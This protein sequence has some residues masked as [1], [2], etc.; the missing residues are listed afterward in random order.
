MATTVTTAGTLI[1][2]S[3]GG[4]G[5][6]GCFAR[7]VDGNLP[8]LLSNAHVLFSDGRNLKNLC[9]SR[10][11]SSSACL[12]RPI[13]KTL[14]SWEAGFTSVTV[15]V[16]DTSTGTTSSQSGSD[17]DCAIAK[18]NPDTV[19][20]N[21]F[22]ANSQIGIIQGTPPS[23]Q[24]GIVVGPT[25]G[26]PAPNQIV[27]MYSPARQVTIEGT[28]VRFTN[29]VAQFAHNALLVP[30]LLYPFTLTRPEDE[31][32]DAKPNINQILIVPLPPHSKFTEPG[33]SGSILLNHLNQAV[34]L[35]CRGIAVP[36]LAGRP[37]F[38]H[39]KELGI[40]NPI[41]SVLNQ[42]KINIPAGFSGTVPSAGN[43]VRI[44]ISHP[45]FDLHTDN[46]QEPINRLQKELSRIRLGRMLMEKHVRH[47]REMRRILNTVRHAST[48][49]Q[50]A[51]GPA[52]VR[53]GAE[54]L[55]DP[56]HVLP[57]VINGVD[58][59]TFVDR[60]ATVFQAYGSPELRRDVERYLP[61]VRDIIT[62][63]TSLHEVT[64]LLN[65]VRRARRNQEYPPGAQL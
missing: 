16:T 30:D 22:P 23:G 38:E 64:S 60:M 12:F 35:I 29:L 41:E 51:Q 34:G 8:V 5:S 31:K 45:G 13:A 54:Q 56:S 32:D 9:I 50:L 49:W 17:T 52:F 26:P 40:A 37:G 6:L 58:R 36:E 24:L 44:F 14:N 53:H 62:R 27:R 1:E 42:L 15:K 61:L 18:L 48:T 4:I 21:S 47:R 65:Q 46:L 11:S 57:T 43:A 33:D 3:A 19:F 25:N 28:I 59:A 7:T 20:S 2:N 55:L 63:V 39:V 10:Q